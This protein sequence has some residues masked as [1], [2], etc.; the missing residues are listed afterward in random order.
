MT[1]ELREAIRRL[2]EDA[3]KEPKAS[4]ANLDYLER[5][6]WLQQTAYFVWKFKGAARPS[7]DEDER[8]G[9]LSR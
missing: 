5:L 2:P 9:R 6:R 4:F 3:F 8:P 7:S 1:E